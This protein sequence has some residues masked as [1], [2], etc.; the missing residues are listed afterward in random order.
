MPPQH[1][2]AQTND[3]AIRL[4]QQEA[5][6]A[7]ERE[8]LLHEQQAPGADVRLPGAETTGTGRL[9]AAETPCFVIQRIELIDDSGHFAWARAAADLPDDP[10]TGR[11]LGSQ[12]INLVM[13]RIQNAIV[14]RGYVTTRV[15]AEAQDLTAGTLAR[16]VMPGRLR[17]VRFTEDSSPRANAWNV[18]PVRPGQL[19]NLRDLEQALE[20]F[21]RLPSAEADL[22]LVP[23]DAPGESDV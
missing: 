19:L 8:R 7:R 13:A 5:Q 16:R 3:A 1:G 22:Q 17:S 11:C 4:D 15:L 23:A 18:F 12:G 14:E 2:V 21:K 6:R 9:P 10:A 20:N